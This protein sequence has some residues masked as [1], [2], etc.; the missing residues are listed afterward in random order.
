[1]VAIN[2]S[3]PSFLQF[4][5]GIPRNSI[6]CTQT[7]PKKIIILSKFKPKEQNQ[8]IPT[9]SLRPFLVEA[10]Q[11]KQPT[12]GKK[13]ISAFREMKLYSPEHYSTISHFQTVQNSLDI[14]SKIKCTPNIFD[15]FFFFFVIFFRS[16]Q[17]PNKK[18]HLPPQ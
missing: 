1:M 15:L 9:N 16:Y 6:P 5:V 12:H 13:K 14:L 18:S 2:G 17:L 10:G 4:Q 3:S 11:I 7:G 8:Q